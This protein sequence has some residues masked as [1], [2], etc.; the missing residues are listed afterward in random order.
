M[1]EY[2]VESANVP[3]AERLVRCA[4]C[5]FWKTGIAYDTVGRCTHEDHNRQITNKNYYCKD[6][7][8]K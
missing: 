2:I 3:I 1:A 5:K 6:G 4:D 7:E 8:P